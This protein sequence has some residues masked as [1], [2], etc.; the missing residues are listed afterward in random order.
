MAFA[1]CEKNLLYVAV[2]LHERGKKLRMELDA[3]MM[4]YYFSI[5]F[6]SLH[7]LKAFDINLHLI[8]SKFRCC[9]L[10]SMVL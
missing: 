7:S 5:V 2:V 6:P 10:V 1:D 8:E 9:L 4:R 3:T